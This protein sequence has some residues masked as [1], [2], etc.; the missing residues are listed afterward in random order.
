MRTGLRNYGTF[1]Y[2]NKKLV[3]KIKDTKL[4]KDTKSPPV[5]QKDH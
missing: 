2:Y 5:V 4:I 1:I 3:F